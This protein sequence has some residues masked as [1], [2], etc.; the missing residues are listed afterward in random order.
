MRKIS[1]ILLLPLLLTACG[2]SELLSAQDKRNNFDA[3]K[4]S[5]LKQISEKDYKT[6]QSTFDKQAEEGC[7][8]L[9]TADA[10]TLKNFSSPKP[11]KIESTEKSATSFQQVCDKIKKAAYAHNEMTN[12]DD[13]ADDYYDKWYGKI[14]GYFRDA[15]SMMRSL[16]GNYTGLIADAQS[17]STSARGVNAGGL[18]YAEERLYSACKISEDAVSAD[19]MKWLDKKYPDSSEEDDSEE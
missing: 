14:R 16:G 13:D 12:Y 1:M 19:F 5:F 3:C 4:I 7:A 18:S 6:N 9:L 15:A 8:P 11:I 10:S 2:N 17:A